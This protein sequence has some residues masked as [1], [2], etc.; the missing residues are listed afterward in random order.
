M[1][2][3]KKKPSVKGQETL[4]KF[5][6][7]QRPV[8]AVQQAKEP[9]ENQGRFNDNWLRDPE[10][11]EWLYRNEK[12]TLTFAWSAR[13]KINFDCAIQRPA[14]PAALFAR[15]GGVHRRF[16]DIPVAATELRSV[17]P[18]SFANS[19]PICRFRH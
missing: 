18:E 12:A 13:I 6:G 10:L 19:I 8:R 7:M 5:V 2:M 3:S 1:T 11:E 9:G 15:V 14:S 17:S 16:S 4:T